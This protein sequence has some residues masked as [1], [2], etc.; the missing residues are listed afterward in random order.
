MKPTEFYSI[1][2]LHGL[3]DM[4]LRFCLYFSEIDDAECRAL[5]NLGRVYARSGSFQKA[6]DV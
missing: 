5:D 4:T 1:K 2:I 3:D 6:I